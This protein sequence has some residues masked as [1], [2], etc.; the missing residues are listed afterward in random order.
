MVVVDFAGNVSKGV[1]DIDK[2]VLKLVNGTSLM[3]EFSESYSNLVKVFGLPNGK[4]DGYKVDAEWIIITPE[5]VATIYNYKD[6]KNYL[7]EQGLEVKD[8]TEWHIGGHSEEVV[9]YIIG[10][11]KG[12]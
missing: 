11:L 9:K 7:E 6:G 10:A 12:A 5:G 4:S 8:I 2:A 3:N 1:K